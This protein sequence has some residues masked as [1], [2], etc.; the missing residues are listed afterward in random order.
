MAFRQTQQ[1]PSEDTGDTVSYQ[2][3]LHEVKHLHYLLYDELL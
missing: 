1:N 3:S 2:V